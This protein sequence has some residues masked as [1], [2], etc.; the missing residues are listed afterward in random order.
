MFA[1]SPTL[2][3]AGLGRSVLAEAE[4]VARTEW[5]ATTMEM[6]VIAQRVDLIAYYERRGFRSTGRT[7]PFPYGEE[8]Y[9]LPQRDDLCFVTLVK[10]LP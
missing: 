9:G 6:T 1:V 4:R 7:L 2:Q 8:R 10:P 5:A 3:G